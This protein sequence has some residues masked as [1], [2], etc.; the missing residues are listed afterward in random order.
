MPRASADKSYFKFTA[1]KIT[2][3]SPL[4]FPENSMKDELN[5][6][7]NFDGTIQRRRGVDYEWDYSLDNSF[8]KLD[9]A[10]LSQTFVWENVRGFREETPVLVIR[11][12][13]KL[14]F[15]RSYAEPVSLSK[16][17]PDLEL[18]EGSVGDTEEVSFA[19]GKG[20]LLAA[21]GSF[22][23]TYIEYDSVEGVFSKTPISIEIRDLEGVDD[24]LPDEKRPSDLTGLHMYSLINQG[25]PYKPTP[26]NQLAGTQMISSGNDS[27]RN[28]RRIASDY[29]GLRQSV[30]PSNSDIY[31]D[32]IE[33]GGLS[34]QILAASYDRAGAAPKG[35][36]VIKAFQE[37]R[38]DLSQ[39]YSSKSSP[40]SPWLPGDYEEKQT[41]KRPTA[42]AFFQGHVLYSGVGDLDY[43]DK[44]YVSQ[45]LVGDDRF[46]KC[47][48]VNDPTADIESSPL[49]TDG[50]VIEIGGVGQVLSLQ[51]IGSQ[52]LIIAT[53]G[54]W[55]IGSQDSAF[56][57]NSVNMSKISIAGALSSGSV[58]LFE[59]SVFYWS[60]DGIYIVTRDPQL[61]T[62]SVSNAIEN[63]I[64][65]A[66][67][68]IPVNK[69]KCVATITDQTDRKVYWLYSNEAEDT[70][71]S[72]Y[73]RALIFDIRAQAF[74][75]YEFSS[76]EGYPYVSG[77]YA[78]PPV[79]EAVFNRDIV[80]G[81]DQVV[82]GV[83]DVV[84]S[85]SVTVGTGGG[86][87]L[88]L[89]TF[90]EDAPGEV[91]YTFSDISNRKFVDW[92]TYDGEGLD[93]SSYIETGYELLG[94]AMKEKQ[95]TYVFCYFNRTEDNF[96][97]SED[98]IVFDY[99]SACRLYG[100]WDWTGTSTANKWSDS[101]QVYRFLRSF[102]PEVGPFDYSFDV[103]ETK[104]KVRG[105]GKAVSLRFESEPKKDFQRLG[106]AINYTGESVA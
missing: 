69:K 16:V 14:S 5:I 2:E 90:V 81:T 23:P 6:D 38:K 28:F 41:A 57:V 93:F 3:A 12:G 97:S 37:N 18:Y 36:V 71:L 46:G 24:G 40:V 33:I 9:D 49:D 65:S 10:A 83:D 80:V 86:S 7:I 105:S 91:H 4:T 32:Y 64:Q 52:C 53:N 100:K 87:A 72:R 15:F 82:I 34:A 55:A 103:I 43:S 19:S 62:L 35:K 8:Q 63:T 60:P 98:G 58:S 13:S 29:Y 48:S 26:Y 95:A 54:V 59:S 85:G 70:N 50:G 56:T 45:S 101:Q 25:W 67:T 99:P 17:A 77:G 84:L 31:S 1:G 104:N 106:W 76:E 47:Y 78:K 27:V 21:G 30:Y 44:I 20:Y 96:I 79:E 94:D 75:D 61:G 102:V 73:N 22:D 66:Y 51:P 39:D 11:Y 74:Y 92:E 42:I 89:L 88:K 68:E